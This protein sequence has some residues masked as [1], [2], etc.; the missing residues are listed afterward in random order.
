MFFSLETSF[1]R[2]GTLNWR[3]RSDSQAHCALVAGRGTRR[4]V[5]C[6]LYDLHETLAPR[7]TRYLNGESRVP[8]TRSP[9][10]PVKNTGPDR[11]DGPPTCRPSTH[12]PRVLP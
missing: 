9:S 8:N 7:L 3:R 12:E 5:A 2:S 11:P 4:K 1:N 6:P 10:D